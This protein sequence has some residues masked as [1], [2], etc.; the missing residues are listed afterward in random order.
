MTNTQIGKYA[1]YNIFL[2]FLESY[3]TVFGTT[4]QQLNN[5]VAALKTAIAFLKTLLPQDSKSATATESITEDKDT[6]FL[7]MKNVTIGMSKL[8]LE[9]AKSTPAAK[10]LIKSFKITSKSFNNSEPEDVAICKTIL[11]LLQDNDT[12]IIAATDITAQQITDF[13]GII[14]SAEAGI[15]LP[16]Q[17]KGQTKVVTNN[18]KLAFADVDAKILSVQNALLGKYGP[19]LP[20]ANKDVIDNMVVAL[21]VTIVKRYTALKL[22]FTNLITG[23]PIEFVKADIPVLKKSVSSDING[24]GHIKSLKA[25][26]AHANFV[27]PLFQTVSQDVTPVKGKTVV[28]NIAMKPI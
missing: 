9:W 1:M 20:A 16:A 23:L 8:A 7:I 26:K 15:G 2:L 18:I 17:Q 28:I 25:K 19:N 24:L 10:S 12:A 14:N 3:K 11:G 4:N 22:F 5:A 27:H 13:E 6:A 21:Q